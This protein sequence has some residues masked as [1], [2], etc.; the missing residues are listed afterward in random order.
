MS[1]GDCDNRVK[2]LFDGLQW[3]GVIDDDKLVKRFSVNSIKSS[4]KD[5]RCVIEIHELTGM[6]EWVGL[7]QKFY[8]LDSC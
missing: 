8:G 7:I 3:G 1:R 4:R 6:R 5:H 2:T